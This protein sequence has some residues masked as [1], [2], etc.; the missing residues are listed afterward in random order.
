MRVLII[1]DDPAIAQALKDGLRQES[2]AVDVACEGDE[3]L[4]AAANEDYDLIILDGMLPGLDGLEVASRLRQQAQHARILM[5]SARDQTADKIQGLNK[6]VDD[7]MV[8]P[9][10]FEEL[11]ARINAL[12]RRPAETKG[13]TLQIADLS[14]NTI[15]HEVRRAGT[16]LRLSPKEFAVLE[17]LLRNQGRVLSKDTIVT[18]VWDFDA[19]ILPHTV[20]TFIAF[21]RAKIDKPFAGPKLIHTLR[22]IG[23]KLSNKP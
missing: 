18:H 16:A 2:F 13:E 20:E 7:Y 19:D 22:G 10:S 11:L 6:G 1:E 12:L 14:L 15:T 5:L 3:G 4:A 23:Y 8:K 21:L 9:F 17:Y